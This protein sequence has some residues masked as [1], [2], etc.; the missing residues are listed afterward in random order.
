MATHS[1]AI[2]AHSDGVAPF[3]LW[4]GHSYAD[5]GPGSVKCATSTQ[6]P[7]GDGTPLMLPCAGVGYSHITLKYSGRQRGLQLRELVVFAPPSGPAAPR[8]SRGLDAL[9]T[10]Y[11]QGR[12]SERV[13]EAGVLFHKFD[14]YLAE[15]PWALDAVYDHMSTSLS[16]ASLTSTYGGTPW[17]WFPG[18]DYA[19]FVL[20][21]VSYCLPSL[22]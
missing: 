2:Y 16:T 11:V 17:G 18:R 19:G 15:Q 12:P 9:N 7:P 20:A 4:L 5:T 6:N 3:E 21:Q 14:D 13:S 22:A 8:P 10:R 1:V